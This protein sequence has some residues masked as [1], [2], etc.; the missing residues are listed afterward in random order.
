MFPLLVTTATATSV[1]Q[2]TCVIEER[3]FLR[4][5][6]YLS[7]ERDDDKYKGVAGYIYTSKDREGHDE[8][9]KEYEVEE[10]EMRAVT[11]DIAAAESAGLYGEREGVQSSDLAFRPEERELDYPIAR[12]GEEHTHTH[13]TAA[14]QQ[15]HGEKLGETS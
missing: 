4:H 1:E 8:G 13:S 3:F 9:E 15:P 10:E 14:E 2:Q 5:G 11:G 7:N 6:P 12:H